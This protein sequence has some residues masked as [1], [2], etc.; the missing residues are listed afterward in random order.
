MSY[1]FYRNLP[2]FDPL[3]SL[4][5][6]MNQGNKGGTEQNGRKR[7]Q[8]IQLNHLFAARLWASHSPTLDFHFPTCKM[9]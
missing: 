5:C 1:L 8:D 7:R 9:F 6:R 4:Q 3:I 2:G